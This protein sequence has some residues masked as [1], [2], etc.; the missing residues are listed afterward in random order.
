M[1]DKREDVRSKEKRRFGREDE[2]VE[3]GREWRWNRGVLSLKDRG[4]EEGPSAWKGVCV[5][6][7][8]R[9]DQYACRLGTA[10]MLNSQD[11]SSRDE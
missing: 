3:S 9:L 6:A 11:G 8:V 1:R 5:C 4:E 10:W 7:C 2:T